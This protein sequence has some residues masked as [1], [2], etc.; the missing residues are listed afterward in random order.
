MW[1]LCPLA[2]AQLPF[3]TLQFKTKE[4]TRKEN[5]TVSVSIRGSPCLTALLNS[6]HPETENRSGK[7]LQSRFSSSEMRTL[8]DPT[9][10]RKDCPWR[11]IALSWVPVQRSPTRSPRGAR[12]H[13]LRTCHPAKH[14][15]QRQ[16]HFLVRERL[17]KLRLQPSD[18]PAE[19]VDRPVCETHPETTCSRVNCAQH[20]QHP[21]CKCDP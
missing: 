5:L 20:V 17:H 21:D 1:Y 14:L 11:V 8:S 15:G 19:D 18:E 12:P 10:I 4:T 7:C 2:P 3:K 6:V 13:T 16:E 9:N